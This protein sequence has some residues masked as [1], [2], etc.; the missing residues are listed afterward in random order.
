MSETKDKCEGLLLRVVLFGAIISACFS[1]CWG[2]SFARPEPPEVRAIPATEIDTLVVDIDDA[3]HHLR[4]QPTEIAKDTL[5]DWAV[6][7]TLIQMRLDPSAVAR[8]SRGILP[9]R[10]RAAAESKDLAHG[11]GRVAVVSDVEALVF[12][13]ESD[14][15]AARTEQRLRGEIPHGPGGKPVTVHAFRI[16][17]DV[18][19][20]EIR[21]ERI[22]SELMKPDAGPDAHHASVLEDGVRD[23]LRGIAEEPT[24]ALAK[25]GRGRSGGR[26]SG[27]STGHSTQGSSHSTYDGSTHTSTSNVSSAPKVPWRNWTAPT[28]P[29]HPQPVSVDVDTKLEDETSESSK[30]KVSIEALPGERLRVTQDRRRAGAAVAEENVAIL[31]GGRAKGDRVKLR[32]TRAAGDTNHTKPAEATTVAV[33]VLTPEDGTAS[34]KPPSVDPELQ[35]ALD[36]IQKDDGR[37]ALKSM[38]QAVGKDPVQTAA[39]AEAFHAQVVARADQHLAH[40]AGPEA[41][42]LYD[43]AAEIEDGDSTEFELGR[44]LADIQSGRAQR[45]LS[46]LGD[47]ERLSPEDLARIEGTPMLGD[48]SGYLAARQDPARE[49]LGVPARELTL[50]VDGTEVR[51]ALKITRFPA[52]QQIQMEDRARIAASPGDTVFYIDDRISLNRHDLETSGHGSL[53]EIAV[54]PDVQWEDVV[55]AGELHLPGMLIDTSDG[56]R[57]RQVTLGATSTGDGPRSRRHVRIH[58]THPPHKDCDADGNGLVSEAERTSCPP[59]RVL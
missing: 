48:L 7:G 36:S 28:R 44:A 47:L 35:K 24:V 58:S 12:V 17:A 53:A 33:H 14:P 32:L 16:S 59:S 52:G 30:T 27:H 10:P 54:S 5:R 57:Y 38:L 45:G 37:G 23:L 11:S 56:K 18:A 26:S 1:S 29:R 41:G 9:A 25:F 13:D 51:S 4:G 3:V 15:D 22:S 43:L 46:R 20:A 34:V 40:G 2:A 39:V 21:V 19:A 31:S 49:I 55:M 8:A 50:V 6:Y 42:S